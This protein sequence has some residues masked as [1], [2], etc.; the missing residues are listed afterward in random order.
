M[1]T[2]TLTA[3]FKI[4]TILDEAEKDLKDFSAAT[5]DMWQGQKPPKAISKALEE[6]RQ[7]ITSIKETSKGEMLDSS[8]LA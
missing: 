1:N 7:R 5:K 2:K 6:L 4:V 8:G 3:Q